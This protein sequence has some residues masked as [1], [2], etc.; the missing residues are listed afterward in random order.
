MSREISADKNNS[1]L[2]VTP[3]LNGL[4]GVANYYKTI[5]PLLGASEFSIDFLEI[6]SAK[7]KGNIFYPITDQFDFFRRIKDTSP[8]LMHINPS[9][10]PKSFVRDGVL[11]YQA[12]RKQIPVIVFFHGW[13]IE[14][15]T[16]IEKYY[17][18]F[19][20]LTF[21]KADAFIVLASEFKEKLR[22]WNV[23]APIFTETTAVDPS[24]LEDFDIERKTADILGK[25]FFQ[26]LY[27]GRIEQA[28]GI[29]E[30]VDA[31]KMLCDKNLPASLS[32][33]GDGPALQELSRYVDSLRLPPGTINFLGYVREQEKASAF[34]SHDIYCFP[35]SYREGM[36]I[37][38]L[39]ALSF[40][41][42]VITCPVGGIAD[43]FH[44]REMG[45]LVPPRN[46]EAI[47]GKIEQMIS[48]RGSMVQMA[49][50]NHDYAK[51]HFLAPKVADRLL[52]IYR[53]AIQ[54]DTNV[55]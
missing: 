5:L 17:L 38:L 9:L 37:S 47:A 6:G 42:P 55:K 49:K 27:L 11:I 3:S 22:H 30:T 25:E 48:E 16:R 36:P 32:I 33:A 4:G 20:K 24:L 7:G 18:R 51:K 52:D 34:A 15:A 12:I 14:F 53:Q 21:G 39:E 2:L 8:V 13:D 43:I 54:A 26:I 40:G 28:K 29:F 23:S 44:D 19:F 41:M 45:A 35:S 50:Y 46:P 10:D 31:I 1:I